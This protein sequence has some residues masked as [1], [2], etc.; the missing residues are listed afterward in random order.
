MLSILVAG[1]VYTLGESSAAELVGRAPGPLA[2]KL[3][4]AIHAHEPEQLDDGEL[5]TLGTVI[6][7]WAT[8]LGV[9][10]AD[11][12]ELREAIADHLG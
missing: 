4:D 10:A 5:A 2:D 11:V 1:H 6:E 9:D 7:A 12:Q 8:E 3:R